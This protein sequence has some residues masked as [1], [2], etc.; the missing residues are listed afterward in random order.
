MFKTKWKYFLIIQELD[1]GLQ[2]TQELF[3]KS[4]GEAEKEAETVLALYSQKCDNHTLLEAHIIKKLM[5]VKK[6]E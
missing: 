4:Q 6:G 1:K 3:S 5:L 2:I